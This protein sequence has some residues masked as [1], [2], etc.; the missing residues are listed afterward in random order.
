MPTP[1]QS[2]PF[3]LRHRLGRAAWGVVYTLLFRPSPEILHGWRRALLRLF[4]ARIDSAARVYPTAR[5]WAPWNLELLPHACIGRAVDVYNVA[6][7][8]VGARSTVSQYTYL[9]GA[10]HDHTQSSYPLIPGHIT[11][12]DDCW[13]AADAFVGPGVTIHD[14]VV[15]GARSSVFADLPPW[16]VCVGTPARPAKPREFDARPSA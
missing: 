12:G 15:V 3:S 9:C 4:G 13:V 11:I 10:T 5:V 6:P 16:T 8:R 1:P 2:S 14:G 7:V